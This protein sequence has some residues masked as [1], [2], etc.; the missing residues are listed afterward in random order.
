MPNLREFDFYTKGNIGA[1]NTDR[2]DLEKQFREFNLTVKEDFDD[3]LEAA[4]ELP[5][6]FPDG[7]SCKVTLEYNNYVHLYCGL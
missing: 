6:Y 3:Y 1:I 7:I 2:D 5:R 4:V